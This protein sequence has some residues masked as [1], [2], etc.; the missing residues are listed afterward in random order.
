MADTVTIATYFS[1]TVSDKAGAGAQL[2]TA[3]KDAGVN[4]TGFWGYPVKGKKAQFDLIPADAKLF[5]KVAKKLGLGI[6]KQSSLVVTGADRPGALAEI[7][8]KLG[9]AGISINA[10]QALSGTEGQFAALVQVA[11]ENVK[12]AR[13]ALA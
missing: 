8:A 1:L 10:A 9:A 12:K 3:L 7:A 2:L 6:A 4:L 13:K 11:A 5:A